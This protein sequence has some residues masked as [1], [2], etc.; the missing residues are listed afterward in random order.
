MF[1]INNSVYLYLAVGRFDQPKSHKSSSL[2]P[3]RALS[4]ILRPTRM[5]TALESPS[6]ILLRSAHRLWVLTKACPSRSPSASSRQPLSSAYLSRLPL[7]LVS[8]NHSQVYFTFHPEFTRSN[9]LFSNTPTR[10]PIQ[11]IHYSNSITYHDDSGNNKVV[12]YKLK[13]HSHLLN[14]GTFLPIPNII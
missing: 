11:T 1:F 6:P 10:C 3:W 2:D 5:S 4:I 9:S 14:K 13:Y 12:Q 7:Y 8:S